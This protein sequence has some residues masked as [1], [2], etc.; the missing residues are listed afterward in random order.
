MGSDDGVCPLYCSQ[1]SANKK[2]KNCQD[3]YN[4]V[5]VK[6]NDNNPIICDNT[7][8]LNGYYKDENNTYYLC[9]EECE[10]C[11]NKEDKCTSC[12]E[13]YYLLEE[14]NKCYNE[15]NYP[16]GYYIDKDKKVLLACYKNC[17]TCSEG[18]V[19]SKKMNC[20]TC[21]AGFTYDKD[22]K[23]CSEKSS[24]VILWIFIINMLLLLCGIVIAYIIIRRKRNQDFSK[25]IEML[26]KDGTI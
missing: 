5:G 12:K 25:N 17:A 6:P 15:E 1:C 2:C 22:N 21:K 23:N 8:N 18:A 9:S 24:N 11:V 19:S 4:L 14:K 26:N 10:N 16:K 20:D 7:I 13:N 3:G